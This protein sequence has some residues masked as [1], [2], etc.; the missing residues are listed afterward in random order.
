MRA[1]F[2]EIAPVFTDDEADVLAARD[3]FMKRGSE[4]AARHRAPREASEP[5]SES[6]SAPASEPPAET[7]LVQCAADVKPQPVTWLWP[8][9]LPAGKLTVLAGAA[10]T[11]KT[12]L[13]LNLAAVVSRGGAWPDG[14][15]CEHPGQVLVWSSEDDVSDTLVPRL[16]A[17]GADLSKIHFVRNV[18]KTDGELVPFDPARDMPLLSTRM[19]DTVRREAGS[20]RARTRGTGA[21][22]GRPDRRGNDRCSV[23][24]A[25]SAH[26]HER[27]AGGLHEG[28]ERA[29]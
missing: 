18:A 10:G 17:A 29:R 28:G 12:T 1:V 6:S 16:M 15:A 23:A 7:V 2:P 9:W 26:A 27:R 8:D 11:G 14:S 13:A 25:E 3:A 19:A 21:R 24:Q 22:R 20:P 5:G 4:I